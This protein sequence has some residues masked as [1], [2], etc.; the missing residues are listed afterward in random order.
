MHFAL[1][2]PFKEAAFG[3][4]VKSCLDANLER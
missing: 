4:K 1:Y 3:P 2:S